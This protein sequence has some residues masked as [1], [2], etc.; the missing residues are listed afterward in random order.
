[1]TAVVRQVIGGLVPRAD[2]VRMNVQ[3]DR[4][5]D[6]PRVHVAEQRGDHPGPLARRLPVL[7]GREQR[8]PL[9]AGRRLLD[10]VAEDVV[11]AVPVDQHQRADAGAAQG[12]R[13]VPHHRVQRD[14]GDAD[15]PRPGRVLV[16]AGDRHRR[17]EVHRVRCRDLPGDGTGDE[18][19]GG[20]RKVRPVLLV[21]AHG[22]DGDLC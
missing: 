8:E 22:K 5:L 3:Q 21:A 6:L 19:V 1:M 16:R 4:R 17:K 18:R 14:G 9:P 15:G 10:D 12:V 13:D 11:P 7:D 20:Q 2:K